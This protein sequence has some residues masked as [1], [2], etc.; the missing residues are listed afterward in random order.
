MEAEVQEP[1]HEGPQSLSSS[2]NGES[3]D[4][5]GEGNKCD[6]ETKMK[7]FEEV[8]GKIRV[9]EERRRSNQEVLLL[10]NRILFPPI[11]GPVLFFCLAS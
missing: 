9:S 4:E 3:Q 1:K 8:D 7:C 5:V 2:G 10:S 11:L 6:R